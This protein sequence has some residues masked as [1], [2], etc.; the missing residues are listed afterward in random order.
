MECP[1]CFKTNN[2]Y[3][4]WKPCLHCFCIKCYRTWCIKNNTCPLCRI[5]KKNHFIDSLYQIRYD[6]FHGP[7]CIIIP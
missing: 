4:R 3:L 6:L 2:K 1:I 7:N 5:V